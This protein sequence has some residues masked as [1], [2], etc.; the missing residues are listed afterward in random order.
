MTPR[1]TKEETQ[2]TDGCGA[3][4]QRVRPWWSGPVPLIEKVTTKG[5]S[6]DPK[7]EGIQLVQDAW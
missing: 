2:H 4:P 7:K 1:A 3:R 6:I 5:T